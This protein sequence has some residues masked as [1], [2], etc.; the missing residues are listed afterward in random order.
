V[1]LLRSPPNDCFGVGQIIAQEKHQERSTRSAVTGSLRH[2]NDHTAHVLFY[3]SNLARYVCLPQCAMQYFPGGSTGHLLVCNEVKRSGA[4]D[5]DRC[6]KTKVKFYEKDD[7]NEEIFI[8]KRK[9]IL[10]K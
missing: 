6:R 2:F 9:K 8:S 3:L 10:S 5:T 4:F 1:G 7:F